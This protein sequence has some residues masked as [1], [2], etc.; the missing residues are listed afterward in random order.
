MAAIKNVIAVYNQIFGLILAT[1][2]GIIENFS[3]D[4]LAI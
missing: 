2:A 1:D 3:D 4:T